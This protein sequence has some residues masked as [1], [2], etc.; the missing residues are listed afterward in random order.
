MGGACRPAERQ[1]KHEQSFGSN[2]LIAK[3]WRRW[4]H[5]KIHLKRT[6][7]EEAVDWIKWAHNTD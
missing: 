7:G 3:P 4:K 6:E 2:E 1:D 5:H